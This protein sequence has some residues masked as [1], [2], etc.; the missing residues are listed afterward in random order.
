MWADWLLG[1]TLFFRTLKLIIRWSHVQT[2]KWLFLTWKK[3]EV[4]H[5]LTQAGYSSPKM[6]KIK[7]ASMAG[8]AVSHLCPSGQHSGHNTSVVLTLYNLTSALCVHGAYETQTSC[9]HTGRGCECHWV[10]RLCYM[11][12]TKGPG[13]QCQS[14]LKWHVRRP[15]P[16]ILYFC[17]IFK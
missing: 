1:V 14:K 10:W 13:P 3:L 17:F 9:W 5:L 2:Y 12:I 11:P 7:R 15:L 4:F 16:N 8:E 6:L